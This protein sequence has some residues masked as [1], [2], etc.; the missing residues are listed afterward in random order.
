MRKIILII[1]GLLIVTNQS[2][3]VRIK[4]IARVQGARQNQILGYGVVI[5]L[6][7][8]GDSTANSVTL[9]TIAN[10]MNRFGLTVPDTSIKANNSAI[11]VVTA[12]L[13][14]FIR[15]G[16]KMD[17]TVSSIG[18]CKSLQGGVL[19]QTPLVAADGQVYAV[20]QGALVLG[21][22]FGEVKGAGGASVQKNHPTVGI[23]SEG[24]LIEREVPTELVSVGNTLDI[25]IR[26]PDFTTAARLAQAL[27]AYHVSEIATAIDAGTVRV[28]LP[29]DQVDPSKQIQFI[30]DIENVE[31]EPDTVTK[32]VINEKTGT[33]VANSRVKISS[34]A[35]AHGNLIITVAQTDIISQPG[36][37]S[38]GVTTQGTATTLAAGEQ[39]A[40]LKPL[41]D[42][43]TVQDVANALNKLG[44]TPR[45]MMT[46][47]QT[48]KQAG[49]LQAEL[50][51]R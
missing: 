3:A 26:D 33:I 25:S 36:A 11:V 2:E 9:Q 46:I 44:A 17:V 13:P 40:Y 4:D 15:T 47:F 16:S 48:I 30:S 37:F 35:V 14:P 49:A 43:P 5:G 51:V 34:V 23:I 39:K 24:A 21:G 22:F 19:M 18:D 31:L 32:V 50:I 7:G 6:A 45:D 27:N 1:L 29:L 10:F 12:D 8:T 20:A 42:L 38:G 41:P 28:N